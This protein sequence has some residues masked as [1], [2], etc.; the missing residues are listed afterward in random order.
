MTLGEFLQQAP[1]LSSAPLN[2]QMMAQPLQ[3]FLITPR[4]EAADVPLYRPPGLIIAPLG[5]EVIPPPSRGED[6]TPVTPSTPAPEGDSLPKEIIE[7]DAVRLVYSREIDSAASFLR[8]ELPVLIICE[9][10][11]VAHLWPEIARRA[12]LT[13]VEVRVEEEDNGMMP[14]SLRQRQLAALKEL[15]ETLK[16][17]DVL[18]IPHLDLLASGSDHNLPTESREL[19]ELV[20]KQSDRLILAFADR[21]QELPEVLAARFAV[22]LLL[23]GVSANVVYP[24]GQEVCLGQAL[25][26]AAE[27]A[28]FQD[29]EPKEL[30]K[31]VAGMNP[32]RIR[33]AIRYAVQEQNPAEP[34][35]VSQMYRAIRAF[36]A[37]TSL[38]FEVPNVTFEEIGGYGEVKAELQ[39][40]LNLM[41]GSYKLPNEKLRSELIPRGFIFYGPP[42]TGKTL[43]AKAVA[44]QL[45]ATI[46][47][48]SGPEVTDMYVGE[49]ERKVREL[50]AE[51]R[52]NAP[53]VLV[54]DEF[55]SIA[56]QRSGR[57][58]GGSRAGNALVAQILTEMDGFRPD[59]PMLVI[60][61]T[62]RIDIIDPALLRPSRFKAIAI[63][64]PDLIARQA[65][66]QVHARHFNLELS[67]ELLYLVAQNTEGMNGDE[68]RAIFR[69]ACLSSCCEDIPVDAYRLGELV[70]KIRKNTRDR[71]A[72]NPVSRRPLQDR[73]FIPLT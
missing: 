40:A 49:S 17:G 33:Q 58:D 26:T 13:P 55:D 32:I 56:T 67:P 4:Q 64:L 3:N 52:R 68:I 38:N 57:D 21:S 5:A 45:N 12:H 6:T 71:K 73:G 31:N 59:V 15:M 65:I 19:I 1:A 2:P 61:T 53:A 43:F 11:I 46:Q 51:A 18:V 30:Y 20:Y 10:L 41:M 22:R 50:F 42:G 35:P 36:K 14:R 29:Y 63:S 8:A 72:A 27:A 70:G 28:C 24:D 23:S 16:K 7:N 25:V 54:F 69:D 34:V 62:N 48:V 66:A 47:V 37:Q 60:G 9:K 44:N 39:K